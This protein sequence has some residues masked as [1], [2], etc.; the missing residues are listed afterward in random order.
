MY[1]LIEYKRGYHNW[2][3]LIF[4]LLNIIALGLGYVL[5]V[6]LDKIQVVSLNLLT[7]SVYTVYTQFGV[8]LFSPL[9]IITIANDYK[10]KNIAFYKMLGY[11]AFTYFLQKKMFIFVCSIF[12]TVII[13]FTLLLLYG[14]FIMISIFFIKVL[15]VILFYS[16]LSLF[17]AFILVQFLSA[18]FLMIG[19]WVV[20]IFVAQVNPCMKYFAYYDSTSMDYKNYVL[21]L[22]N[23]IEIKQIM[24]DMLNGLVFNSA[25]LGF[26]LLII[27]FSNKIWSKY[28]I[29]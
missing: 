18:F 22:S 11:S 26:T 24:Y 3:I 16:S 14:H 8:F 27:F 7:Q 15:L 20:G 13:S 10:D 28:G 23:K 1:L 29:H 6:S 2:F 4:L 17:F 21:F 19:L 9:F 5:L 12:S 25:V